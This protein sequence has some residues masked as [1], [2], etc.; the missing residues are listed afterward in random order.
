[1]GV[2]R[3]GVRCAIVGGAVMWR[4]VGRHG[5][6]GSGMGVRMGRREGVVVPSCGGR[7]VGVIVGGGVVGVVGT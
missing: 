1:V 6:S 4:E 7:L 3:M 5:V 2:A